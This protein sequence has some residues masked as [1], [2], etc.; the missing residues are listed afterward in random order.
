[1]TNYVPGVLLL[2]LVVAPVGG[3]EPPVKPLIEGV[4]GLQSM[5]VGPNGKLY[6][7]VAGERGSMGKGKVMALD[8]GKTVPFAQGLDEPRGIAGFQGWLFV[9][10]EQRVWKIDARGKANVFAAANAFPHPPKMLTDVTV[11]PESGLVYVSDAGDEQ[12]K[13]SAVYRITPQGKTSVVIDRKRFPQLGMAGAVV[14]DGASFLLVLDSLEGML[15]RVR[16]HDGKAKQVA[17]DLGEGGGLAW[18]M[19]GRLFVSDAKN[20]RIYV[21]GRPGQKPVA[22]AARVDSP[23]DLCL[24]PTRKFLVV[25][26]RSAG[27][28]YAV[29]AT[30]PGAAVDERP[31]ALQPAL[32]FPDLKWTGW[33]AMT[34]KGTLQPHRPILLTHGGDGSNRVFVP[35]QQGVIHVFPNDQK[36][37]S[38][39]VFL[40]IRQK[41][42]YND[43]ENEE[44]FLGLTFHPNYKKNGQ[45]FVF[46]TL[47]L[48]PNQHV[49]V[50]C[51]YK[52][53][54]D[55][56]DRADPNSEEE[57]LRIDRPF[58][59]HDGG[60]ICFGP[61][62]Y[63]YFCTGDGGAANDPY[64]NAQN[65]KSLLGKVLRI[66]VNRKENGKN[67]AIP[68]DN[69]FVNN[70]DARPETWAYGLRNIW[71]MSFDRKTGVLWAG[72]VGQNLYEEIDVITRGGN[73]G[74]KKRE[75]LHPFGNGGI[76]P[77]PD[78]I[79]PIWEYHHDIGKSIIGGHVYRGKWL[80]E[81][82][83]YYLYGDYVTGRI[84][85][86]RYD[87][88]QK[89]VVANRPIPDRSVPIMSFG[90]DEQGEVYFMTYSPTGQGIY[91]FVPAEPKKVP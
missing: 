4:K 75:G 69:P 31:L 54:N 23:A 47:K 9:A 25:A 73:Y 20:G 30:V 18:D 65:L 21:I 86:L 2:F 63:L 15:W 26:D 88:K 80:P 51:R 55:D 17:V 66:D 82:D 61:D 84:W 62:G 71:R 1:M 40:D 38:T 90:E 39:K 14:L 68:K 77:R 87:E 8:K 53:S 76:G 24:D 70:K 43:N 32:A 83:G 79:E 59:N 3:G 72:D 28:L 10:D 27:A 13:D 29:R 34:D 57:L 16:L 85:A 60:T 6:L 78:L 52:V 35:T 37:K 36:A 91:R 5:T 42:R 49:N 81:L 58:W 56:P 11:D 74:W 89:R 41:V 19:F 45:F 46:Y 48:P 50:L 22:L 44:G 33:K 12:G 67:Y 64:N 7:T